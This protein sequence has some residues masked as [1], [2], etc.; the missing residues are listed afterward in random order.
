[1]LLESRVKL[2]GMFPSFA[3]RPVFESTISLQT[4]AAFELNVKNNRHLCNSITHSFIVSV[5]FTYF[6]VFLKE[7]VYVIIQ[8]FNCFAL[9]C[10]TA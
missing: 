1:M 4:S 2:C 9:K 8:Y 6:I 5:G 7:T 10:D 3:V